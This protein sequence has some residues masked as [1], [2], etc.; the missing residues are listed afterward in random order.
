MGRGGGELERGEW[1]R[2]SFNVLLFQLL[3]Y[4]L[5]PQNVRDM[6]IIIAKPVCAKQEK[7][8][9]YILIVI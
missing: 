4:E 1:L 3:K 8:Y 5:C 6:G 2:S 7:S 9:V